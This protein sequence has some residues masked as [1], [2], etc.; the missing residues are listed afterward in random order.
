MYEQTVTDTNF[1]PAV[2]WDVW[3]PRQDE[4]NMNVLQS[5]SDFAGLQLKELLKCQCTTNVLFIFK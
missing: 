2:H 5:F 4:I 3:E 1:K